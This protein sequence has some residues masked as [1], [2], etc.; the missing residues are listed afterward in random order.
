M[1]RILLVFF[2]L[3]FLLAFTNVLSADQM[4]TGCGLGSILWEG[5]DGLFPETCAV[6]TNGTFGT[7]TFGITSGTSNCK[8]KESSASIEKLNKFIADNMDNLAKDIAKGNGE[9][10]NTLAILMEISESKRA[11][12]YNKLQTNFSKI[13]SSDGI[14]SVD[15]L[16]NIE[17]VLKSS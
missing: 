12:F 8:R 3:L 16:N 2:S 9:Y 1:K 11:R 6:T 17:S 7:Q 10:I 15:V 5:K 14:T 4:N 13:F